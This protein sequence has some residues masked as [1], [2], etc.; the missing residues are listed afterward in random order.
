M[1]QEGTVIPGQHYQHR[2][3]NPFRNR[4]IGRYNEEAQHRHAQ[5]WHEGFWEQP[6]I[7][8]VG[9]LNDDPA[10]HPMYQ[11]SLRDHMGFSIEEEDYEP[12]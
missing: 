2:E 4:E 9:D 7:D 3:A 11:Q 8:A 12:V 5:K 1:K 10:D 6:L